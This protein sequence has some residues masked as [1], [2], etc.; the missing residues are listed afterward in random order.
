LGAEKP[1]SA[2]LV[3]VELLTALCSAEVGQK[4]QGSLTK[5]F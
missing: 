5:C 4:I 2:T 3:D 1:S